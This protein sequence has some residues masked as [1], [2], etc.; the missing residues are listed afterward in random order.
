[1]THIHAGAADLLDPSAHLNLIVQARWLLIF[2]F[3]S[4]HREHDAFAIQ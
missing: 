2:D 1:Q 4:A 3:T